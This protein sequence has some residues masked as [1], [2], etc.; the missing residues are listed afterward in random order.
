MK[1][2]LGEGGNGSIDFNQFKAIFNAAAGGMRLIDFDFNIKVVN[3]A[4]LGLVN[5][6]EK[7]VVGR[8]CYDVF[9]GDLCNTDKCPVV[10]LRKNPKKKYVVETPA[11]KEPKISGIPK[12][13]AM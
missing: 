5:L 9:Y 12:K 2:I 11:A 3:E 6:S 8:K 7:Q 10:R 1:K 4:F 13:D